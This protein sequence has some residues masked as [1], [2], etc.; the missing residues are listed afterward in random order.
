M[1]KKKV[2]RHSIYEKDE[3]SPGLLFWRSFQNWQRRIRVVL[4][5]VGVT[6]VQYSILAATS[7]LASDGSI[8]MQQDVANALSMDKMMVSDVVKILLRKKFL[9]RHPH[10]EDARAYALALTS[11]GNRTLNQCVPL[12]ESVDEDFF[13]S[14]G[15]QHKNFMA[16]LKTLS[17]F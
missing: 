7:Y 12:V 6:Q 2:L 9:Q 14:L 13:G 5:P 10:P 17:H 15:T 8:V 4:D 11:F 3:R 1:D 16:C